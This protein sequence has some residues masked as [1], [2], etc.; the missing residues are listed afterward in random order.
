MKKQII[1]RHVE[2]WADLLED[3][4]QSKNM[5]ATLKSIGKNFTPEIGYLFRAFRECPL[6]QVKLV[7]IGQDPYPQKGVA[8]GLAF[9]CSR[10]GKQEVSLEV[11]KEAMFREQ[12][13]DFE[14]VDWKVTDLTYLANQGVLL[15]NAALTCQVGKPGTHYQEWRWFIEGVLERLQDRGL[16]YILYGR[17]AQSLEP[18]IKGKVFK[19]YH[20]IAEK[21]S[22]GHIKFK[23]FLPE[24]QLNLQWLPIDEKQLPEGFEDVD[25]SIGE[26]PKLR[27]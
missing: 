14:P 11:I 10:K 2:T 23:T 7:I 4:F 8:D 9:S 5:D 20:P 24:T 22:E 17:I 6:D 26:Y 15:L 1:E 21:R 18:S 3:L 19:G 12:I 16:T 13:H 25:I 27:L